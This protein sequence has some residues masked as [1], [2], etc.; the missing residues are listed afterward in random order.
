MIARLQDWVAAQVQQRPD[1][2]ALV[3]GAERM[4]YGRLEEISNQLARMLRK[5]GCGGGDRVC[6]L[7]PKSP[8]AIASIFGVLKGGYLLA[9]GSFLFRRRSSLRRPL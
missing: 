4:T 3:L 1:A 5:W 7:L 2:T 6:L 8:T 9:F